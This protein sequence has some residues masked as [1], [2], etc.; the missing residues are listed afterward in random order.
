[1]ITRFMVGFALVA[2]LVVGVG[3]G[4]AQAT[5]VFAQAYGLNCTACHTQMPV[6]NSF[7]RYIQRTGYAAMDRKTLTHAVPGFLF[8]LG[9]SYTHQSGQPA[10]AG[11]I[12]G[13]GNTTVFQ[14]NGYL[15]PDVT[16]KIEQLITAGGRDGVLDQGWLAYHNIL[17]HHGHLFVGKLA[18][19]N[20]DEFSAFVLGDVNDAGQ[21]SVPDVAVG[22][23]DYALDYDGGRWGSRFNYVEGK[24]AVEI[25]YFGNATG[26]GSFND[27]YDFSRA[28]DTSI[29][30]KLAYADPAKPY[31]IGV[32]GESGS[33]GYTG[34]EIGTGLHI[35]RY[36]VIAP[37]IE[38]DPRP[39]SP[40]FRLEYATAT[41]SNPGYHT[42]AQAATP[43]VPV[44]ATASSWMIG[45]VNQM[46]FHDQG[47]VDVTYYHTN[48]TI[49]QTGFTG[50]V[51]PIG[52]T[53][54]IGPGISYA[55][56]PYTRIYGAV[57]TA[58]NQR[59]TFALKVWLS[60]P[61]WGRLK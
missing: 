41:D 38:K 50:F 40:G 10:S 34:T 9:T 5:P 24:T 54:G 59:P 42:P 52:P 61:L 43:L 19:V 16:Y 33:L 55:I 53:T 23:H 48:Q 15:A 32:F 13:P 22:V 37:Y 3:R 7:G 46:V 1:M 17:N 20:L 45:S 28:A 49:A 44:G 57:Y 8:D 25:A 56:N 47:L 4:G 2:A 39:G 26:G 30:W 21:G 11:R 35:D 29:Q 31:E 14:G 27:A 51:R 60:P 58:Q 36:T 18:E 6:L 12:T